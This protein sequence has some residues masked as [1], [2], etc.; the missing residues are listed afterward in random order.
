MRIFFKHF[1][2]FSAFFRA[3]INGLSWIVVIWGLGVL[4]ETGM[5]GKIMLVALVALALLAQVA[6]AGFG[7]GLKEKEMNAENENGAVN[8]ANGQ[9]EQGNGSTNGKNS[10]QGNQIK[11]KIKER[12]EEMKEKLEKFRHVRERMSVVGKGFA[13]NDDWSA[14]AM[15]LRIAPGVGAKNGTGNYGTL[16][17]GD[18]AYVVANA[19]RSNDSI[20]ASIYEAN[21]EDFKNC[22]KDD[23]DKNKCLWETEVGSLALTLSK[24]KWMGWYGTGTMEINGTQYH[25]YIS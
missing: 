3:L 6:S 10:G 23:P 25:I 24:G 1:Q 21:R 20:T 5:D 2:V 11:E 15:Y 19:E 13:I 14:Q 18:K 9:E 16:Q 8:Q 4:G 7:M 12:L 17:L 22:I